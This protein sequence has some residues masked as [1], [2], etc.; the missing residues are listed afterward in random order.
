MACV[1]LC[2]GLLDRD[3]LLISSDFFPEAPSH[4]LLKDEQL[5]Q[6]CATV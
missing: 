6:F 4:L 1:Q 2:L 5:F 3:V